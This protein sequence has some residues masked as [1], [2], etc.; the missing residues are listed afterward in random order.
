MAIQKVKNIPI[1]ELRQ[2]F[3]YDPDTGIIR[4]AKRGAGRSKQGKEA[5]TLESSTGYISIGI[6]GTKYT[7]HRLAWAL[8]Y[9]EWPSGEID[10]INGNRA[11]NR[12][13]NIRN[14]THRENSCNQPKHRKGKLTGGTWNKS[15]NK[16]VAQITIDGKKKQLGLFNTAEEAH[17]AYC[18]EL[19]RIDSPFRELD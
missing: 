18:A 11:D 9:D 7:G 19:A 14:V 1:E 13:C 15:M 8:T 5:G 17:Q 3:N 16:W 12:L 6:S 2:F 4:W 10:H